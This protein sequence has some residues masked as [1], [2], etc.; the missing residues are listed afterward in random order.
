VLLEA[1]ATV[2]AHGHV[3]G[4]QDA[5]PAPP[6]A[7]VPQRRQRQ[8]RTYPPSPRP[9][10]GGDVEDPRNPRRERE[11][12]GGEHLPAE[13]AHVVAERVLFR[14][15]Q[16]ATGFEECPGDE[17]R[18]P[19]PSPRNPDVLPQ[20]LGVAHPL[21][22][23][24]VRGRDAPV[25]RPQV[26]GHATQSLRAHQAVRPQPRTEVRRTAKRAH[27]PHKGEPARRVVTAGRLD[28]GVGF[29]CGSLVR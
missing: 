17:P 3:R 5:D 7:R 2:D 28:P 11:R 18:H 23:Q 26:R 12:S 24:P 20:N 10:Q 9:G 4:L 22:G 25:E 21:Y 27:R 13:P 8:R 1:Q 16:N 29:S 6:L 14:Q 15:A 19:E